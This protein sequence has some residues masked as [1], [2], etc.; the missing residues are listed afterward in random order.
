MVTGLSDF[1]RVSRPLHQKDQETQVIRK[2]DSSDC[3][4]RPLSMP[5]SVSAGNVLLS[6]K[7]EKRLLLPLSTLSRYQLTQYCA[8]HKFVEP[9]IDENV[10]KAFGYRLN[11]LLRC[12][13]A[14]ETR[15]VSLSLPQADHVIYR[16][17]RSSK[18]AVPVVTKRL[19][20]PQAD[21][22]FYGSNQAVSLLTKNLDLLSSLRILHSPGKL[23]YY[24]RPPLTFSPTSTISP[25]KII[26]LKLPPPKISAKCQFTILSA[27]HGAFKSIAQ[28]LDQQLK[29]AGQTVQSDERNALLKF[30]RTT[31][32]DRG[33]TCTLNITDSKRRHLSTLLQC[34]PMT[35][36]ISGQLD[37]FVPIARDDFS[38]PLDDR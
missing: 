33:L 28:T 36:L 1:A 21:N 5:T 6:I 27:H 14:V 25:I 19:D 20:F 38:S 31:N 10:G 26:E 32:R 17:I 13:S 22:G 12:Y 24:N 15:Y 29:R 35:A 16:F 11:D 18:H 2:Y 4:T 8:H 34:Q 7:I 23:T 3:K 37:I 9:R 30:A